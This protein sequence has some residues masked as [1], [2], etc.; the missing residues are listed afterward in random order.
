MQVMKSLGESSG[1]GRLQGPEE[2]SRC[3]GVNVGH[4]VVMALNFEGWDFEEGVRRI[5]NWA[6]V[7]GIGV[8]IGS[9]EGRGHGSQECLADVLVMACG[10][11][12]T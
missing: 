2:N 10:G 4:G 9:G 7:I 1:L 5:W 6:E 11:E 12:L 3:R 8:N